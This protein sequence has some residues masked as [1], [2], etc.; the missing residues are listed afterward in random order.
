MSVHG[1]LCKG[2]DEEDRDK[3]NIRLHSDIS[4]ENNAK[5]M[6]TRGGNTE[7]KILDRGCNEKP[8][9]TTEAGAPH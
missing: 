4:R 5:R 8:G 6:R 3:R 9:C 2:V 7:Y 1:S